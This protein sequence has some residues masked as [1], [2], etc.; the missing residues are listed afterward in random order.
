MRAKVACGMADLYRRHLGHHFG[1]TQLH[2]TA[3]RLV[4]YVRGHYTIETLLVLTV[5]LA[6]SWSIPSFFLSVYI[7]YF[8]KVSLV[9]RFD[10]IHSTFHTIPVISVALAI[11]RRSSPLQKI[12]E[13]NM[14][15]GL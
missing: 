15:N 13:Y 3:W 6:V 9:A 7:L 2:P 14:I 12:H 1:T 10:A 4:I 11:K 8:S 5:Q